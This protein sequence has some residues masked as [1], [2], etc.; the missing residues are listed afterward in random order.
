[1][2]RIAILTLSLLFVFAAA[3]ISQTKPAD[4]PKAAAFQWKETTHDFAKI[5]QGKPVTAE[6][7]FKN[8]GS[9]PLVISSAQGS[10]GCTVPEY[11]KEPI[12]PGKEGIVKATFNAA[13]AGAFTKTV[14][15]TANTEKGQEVL[16]IKGE[17][18]AQAAAAQ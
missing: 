15:I 13:N 1:M 4:K 6:F 16:T 3:A 10:C 7:K 18:V 11:S 9:V 2:K 8:T 5:P 14:T 12:A 17:V